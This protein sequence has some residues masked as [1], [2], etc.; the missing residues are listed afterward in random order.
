[1]RHLLDHAEVRM[2]NI[3]IDKVTCG[4]GLA[5]SRRPRAIRATSSRRTDI[6]DGVELRALFE[7][8]RPDA[9]MNLAAESHV[10]RLIGGPGEFVATNVVGTFML[11]REA[12]RHWRMLDL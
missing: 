5:S 11:L 10:D 9:V 4:A 12:L 2:V 6:S 1:V 8:K 3:D 7:R